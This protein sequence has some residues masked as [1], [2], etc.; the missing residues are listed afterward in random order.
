MLIVVKNDSFHHPKLVLSQV[1]IKNGCVI[2]VSQ[3]HNLNYFLYVF[4]FEDF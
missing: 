4:I 3:S 1:R 2:E